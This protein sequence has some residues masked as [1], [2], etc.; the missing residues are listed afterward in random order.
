MQSMV[1]AV[2]TGATNVMMLGGEEYSND[3]T[4]WLQYEPTDPDNNLVASWHSYNGNTC[5]TL[6]CWTSEVQP[7]IAKVPVIA[8]EIGEGDRRDLLR[9]AHELAGVGGHLVPR[10]DLD[11]WAN[12][13]A[14]GP[15]LI[16]D[17]AGDA[18]P[19]GTA[20]KA[21]LQALP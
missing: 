2:L 8:G 13:C 5:D 3:L 20:Y 9:L 12:G 18:T 1:N 14:T 10:L 7:V 19:Y 17:Y 16:T 21:I 11:D 6:S 15:T 4:D